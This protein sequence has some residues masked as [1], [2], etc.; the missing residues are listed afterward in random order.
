MTLVDRVKK[1]VSHTKEKRHSS[2]KNF[3]NH[4]LI[5]SLARGFPLKRKEKQA[6]KHWADVIRRIDVFYV[7]F[8][9]LMLFRILGKRVASHTIDG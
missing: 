7:Y 1:T 3:I 6:E 2:K 8:D 4:I 5:P 9:R